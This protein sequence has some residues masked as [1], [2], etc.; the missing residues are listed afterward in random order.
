MAYTDRIL[1]RDIDELLADHAGPCV[2]IYLP[3]SVITE[4]TD[5]DRIRLKN[6]RSEAFDQLTARGLRRPDAEAILLPVDDI[7]ED[8]SFWPYLSDGLAIYASPGMHAHYR[9]PMSPPPTV[10]VGDR[11]H[12]KPLLPLLTEDGVFHIVAVSQSEVRLLEG[13][14]HHVTPIEIGGA[15][16]NMAEAL[17]RRGRDPGRAPLRRWQGDEGQK[18]LYRQFFTQI[19]RALRPEY[20]RHGAPLVFAGVDYLFPIYREAAAYRY[21]VDAYIAGNPDQMTARE[22]HARAWPIVEPVFAR[23]R[24]DA[25]QTYRSLQGSGRTSADLETIL[26]AALDGR[27]DTLFVDLSADVS[28]TFDETRRIIAVH[29]EPEPGDRDLAAQ[30]ARWAFGTGARIFAGELP[31]IPEGGPVAAIFRYA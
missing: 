16:G 12:L 18:L 7:L 4:D 3:T 13:T 24:Q 15:P 9:V 14:R 30:A 27:V 25:L 8:D 1:E 17:R 19:D 26:G 11:F 28:G 6:L 5:K 20:G 31:E 21:L 22:L 29:E 2:S 10:R 23:P